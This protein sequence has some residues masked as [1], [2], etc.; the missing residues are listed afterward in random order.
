[1]PVKY[2]DVGTGEFLP[3]ALQNTGAPSR[4]GIDTPEKLVQTSLASS[5]GQFTGS[6]KFLVPNRARL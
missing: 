1:M 6:S 3:G 4:Y 2:V 5:H